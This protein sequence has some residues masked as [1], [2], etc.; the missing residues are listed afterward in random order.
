[1]ASFAPNVWLHEKLPAENGYVIRPYVLLSG[2][3]GGYYWRNG[4]KGFWRAFLASE[5]KYFTLTNTGECYIIS[6]YC[7]TCSSESYIF[8]TWCF[9]SG[10]ES[11]TNLESYISESFFH[12]KCRIDEPDLKAAI[13]IVEKM[14][15]IVQYQMSFFLVH[16]IFHRN[17]PP[18]TLLPKQAIQSRS[19]HAKIWKIQRRHA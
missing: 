11:N 18:W 9:Y 12:G 2:Q 3:N 10:R 4:Q 6:E 8:G 17:L 13:G 7:G 15:H 16:R 14:S 1:M 19:N 5:K